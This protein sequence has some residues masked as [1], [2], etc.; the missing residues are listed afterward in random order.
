M[1]EDDATPPRR[2]R[3]QTAGRAGA[4]R[5][6]PATAK[7]A[8]SAE[9]AKPPAR[10]K[11]APAKKPAA[12][13]A[14]A[15][16]PAAE[17]K[18]APAPPP[19]GPRRLNLALQ[20][21]GAHGAFTWGVIDR[22][23]A[24]GRIEIAGI[25]G[26]SAGAMNAIVTASGLERGGADGA[27]AD[28]ADFWGRISAAAKQGPLQPTPLDRLV[29]PGNM[30]FSPFWQ[31]YDNLSR[32]FSPYQLN[33][34]GSNPL[35]AVLEAVVDFEAVR[36]GDGT[37]LFLCA[38]NVKT[39]RIRVFTNREVS[40]DSVLASACLPFLFKAVEIDGDSYWDGGYMGNPPIYPLIYDTDCRDVLIVQ[41]NP[42][43]IPE[44]PRT[45][46]AIYDRV[47]T[48]SFNSSLMREMRAI[49]FVTRLIDDGVLDPDAYRR[50][51]IHTIDAEAEMASLG[52]SS[53]LNADAS[54]L[55]YMKG[56]GETYAQG[57]L[58]D[59]FDKIGVDSSTDIAGKFL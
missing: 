2:R 38:T 33:P 14:R 18:A 56:L 53:K 27:R 51:N 19:K 23:L 5:S 22:L 41:I 58:D 4:G 45:A 7:P 25:C 32:V 26:T 40:V 37:R 17:A 49:H 44:V 52:V 48:L 11:R 15:K 21:G 12:A 59:H 24:D 10:S 20:G 3:T 47:N 9:A 50:I 35:R 43:N 28:L 30:D 42:I 31:I 46:Q 1:A 34:F 39:G 8:K 54:F 13:P 16:A 36:A 6:K 55:G 57:F 29:S